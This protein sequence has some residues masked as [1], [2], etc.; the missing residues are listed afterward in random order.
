LLVREAIRRENL[1]ID[2]HNAS[3]GQQA[4]DFL[5]RAEHDPDAPCPDFLLLDL[6]LPKMDGFEVLRRVR[7]GGKCA[8]IPVV[9]IT[10]SDSPADRS[11]AARLGAGYFR[12]PPNYEEFLKLGGVLKK[13]VE[14]ESAS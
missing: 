1:P 2:L 5:E 13:L 10:S 3:D 11:Q 6:N 4:I 7:T 9:V 14:K 12:K 8:A